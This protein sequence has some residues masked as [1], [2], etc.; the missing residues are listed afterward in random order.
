M[1]I[2]VHT[3]LVV[4]LLLEKIFED[5]SHAEHWLVVP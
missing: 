2:C 3:W 5:H 4:G 1:L